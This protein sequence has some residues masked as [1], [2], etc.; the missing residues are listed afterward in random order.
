M[1]RRRQRPPLPQRRRRLL[2]PWLTEVRVPEKM[3]WDQADL[4]ISLPRSK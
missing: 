1:P 3:P 4:S 2:Q